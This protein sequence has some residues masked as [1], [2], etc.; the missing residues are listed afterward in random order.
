MIRQDP[1]SN[2][3]FS[4]QTD[5]RYITFALSRSFFDGFRLIMKNRIK[6]N[7]CKIFIIIKNYACVGQAMNFWYILNFLGDS[8]NKFLNLCN[9]II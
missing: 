3:F 1:T 5:I 9:L 4:K 2:I 7:F 6:N 8:W